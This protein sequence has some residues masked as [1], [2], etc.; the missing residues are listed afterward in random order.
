MSKQFWSLS[1]VDITFLPGVS[2]TPGQV[3]IPVQAL[4]ARPAVRLHWALRAVH[5][6]LEKTRNFPYFLQVSPVSV[7]QGLSADKFPQVTTGLATRVFKID[8]L[9]QQIGQF[10][11]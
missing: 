3:I 2:K 6:T 4:F 1:R 5:P 10:V 11:D 7:F 8:F 9:N